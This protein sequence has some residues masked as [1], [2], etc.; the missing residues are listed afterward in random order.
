MRL[1]AIDSEMWIWG[2]VCLC[3]FCAKCGSQT[4]KKGQGGAAWLYE[5]YPRIFPVSVSKM[6]G[7][8]WAGFLPVTMYWWQYSSDWKWIW[9]LKPNGCYSSV[10]DVI[11]VS[12][13]HSGHVR[14]VLLSLV[15]W[16]GCHLLHL[17]SLTAVRAPFLSRCTLAIF[18]N[19]NCNH[20]QH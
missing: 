14:A 10:R 7:L 12:L 9:A 6:D 3:R 15:T 4:A 13:L 5:K 16:R 1:V 8:V 20:T 11:T 2:R 17:H 18:C 19:R